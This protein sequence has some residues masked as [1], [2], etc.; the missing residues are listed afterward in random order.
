ME[1][2]SSNGTIM[3]LWSNL[4]GVRKLYKLPEFFRHNIDPPDTN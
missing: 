3:I 1:C 2:A 4:V